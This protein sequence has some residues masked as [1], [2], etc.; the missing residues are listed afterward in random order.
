MIY[1]L[2]DYC[3]ALQIY[4]LLFIYRQLELSY[5]FCPY[6][7]CLHQTEGAEGF[8]P[9]LKLTSW[10][11]KSAGGMWGIQQKS[12]TAGQSS[13]WLFPFVWICKGESFL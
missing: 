6:G 11:N 10:R 2:F 7:L 4:I 1:L 5:C 12:M 8:V 3:F 9:L 13:V